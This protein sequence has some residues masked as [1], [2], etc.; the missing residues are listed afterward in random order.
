M[1]C[2]FCP[3]L[4]AVNLTRRGVAQWCPGSLLPVQTQR[5][6]N[7]RMGRALPIGCVDE[8]GA[9]GATPTGSLIL[10]GG[11]LQGQWWLCVFD[12]RVCVAAAAAAAAA[13]ARA[14]GM[15]GGANN[16]SGPNH[17]VDAAGPVAIYPPV[18]P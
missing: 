6:N 5:P 13:A 14:I 11:S 12:V 18:S 8:E 16:T 10:F 15:L 4:H 1:W 9:W 2:S 17:L 7:A 3:I